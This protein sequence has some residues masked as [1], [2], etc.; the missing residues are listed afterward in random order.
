MLSPTT[1]LNVAF[2]LSG[3]EELHA[4][5][6]SRNSQLLKWRATNTPDPQP[7]C[8]ALAAAGRRVLA[9]A[10]ACIFLR[11]LDLEKPGLDSSI[12]RLLCCFLL[13]LQLQLQ[14]SDL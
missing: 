9:D 8:G 6:V 5:Q 3:Q 13:H 7:A 10:T 2:F 11:I 12:H 14:G 4:W 1:D